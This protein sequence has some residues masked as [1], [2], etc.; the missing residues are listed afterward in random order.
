[1]EIVSCLYFT[2]FT[3]VVSEFKW[4]LLIHISNFCMHL[5]IFSDIYFIGGFG[6]VA[7]IDVKEYEDLQPDKI[8]IDG[9]EQNLKVNF[10]LRDLATYFN[11]PLFYPGR[12]LEKPLKLFI[13]NTFGSFS[14]CNTV[15]DLYI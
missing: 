3:S 11:C 1:M 5:L 9:G 8:A 6:T 12:N 2:E 4:Y 15:H 14:L 13:H 7:W 10:K